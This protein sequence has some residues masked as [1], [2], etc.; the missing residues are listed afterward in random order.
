MEK[1]SQAMPA[2]STDQ[3]LELVKELRKPADPTPEQ[4]AAIEQDKRDRQTQAEL[5]LQ[6]QDNRRAEQEACS[7]MRTGVWAGTTTAVYVQNG[8]FLICQQCQK[9]IRP[10]NEPQ[11]FNRLI[12]SQAQANF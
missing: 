8:N 2:M 6:I 1:Q 7:H 5:S 10:E 3:F 9:I 11:L 4:Q 12:Q